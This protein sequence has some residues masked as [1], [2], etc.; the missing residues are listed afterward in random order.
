M[1]LDRVKTD[2]KVLS[3]LFAREVFG[4]ELNDPPLAPA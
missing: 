4:D 1:I 2:A 3:D